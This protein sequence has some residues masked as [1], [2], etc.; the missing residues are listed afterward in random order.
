M[1]IAVDIFK[2]QNVIFFTQTSERESDRTDLILNFCKL[3]EMEKRVDPQK[4]QGTA[5]NQDGGSL[6]LCGV[7]VKHCVLSFRV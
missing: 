5:Q 4:D 2:K 1:F 7:D 6:A 3:K